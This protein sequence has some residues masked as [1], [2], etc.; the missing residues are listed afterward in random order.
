MKCTLII[1]DECNI[2]FEGLSPECRR[3]MVTSLEFFVPGAK[4]LPA[5]RLGRWNGKMSFCDIGGRSYL[6]LLDTLL[7]IVQQHGYEVEIEDRRLVTESFEFE[8][9]DTDS[10]KNVLWP[11]GHPYAGH[12]IL[13]KDHQV[14]MINSYLENLQSINI[15]PTAGGK[16]LITG[17]LSHKVQKYGRSLVIVPSKDLVTQTEIDYKNLGLDVGVFFGDRKDY[18]KTHTICTWQSLE[19]LHKNKD[20]DEM[21]AFI[22]D[23]VCVI[24]D[25]CHRAKGAVLRSLLGGPLANVPIRWGLTGT[26]PE[27]Q[28]DK[29]A[30]ISCIGA[31]NNEI[32]TKDL[33][34]KGILAGIHIDI[35]QLQDPATSY[36]TYQEELKW[37]TSNKSRLDFIAD[38][39]QNVFSTGSTL[40]LVDRIS[41]GE[42]L[43]EL[44]DGSVFVSGKMKSKDRKLEYNEVQEINNKVIIATYGIA[45]TGTNIPRLYNLVLLE[46]GKGFVRVIQSIGRGLRVTSDK[47][48]INVYDITSL[49]FNNSYNNGFAISY[50]YNASTQIY[51]IT[52]RTGNTNIALI[53]INNAY[54]SYS[55][56]QYRIYI[57]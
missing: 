56:G 57:Y 54:T 13:I 42:L 2:K 4:Y 24:S 7:P 19:A 17:I 26:M 23:V 49:Y 3:K 33:Q 36:G 31:Q 12:P 32:K 52:V 25:E 18:N 38:K 15:I 29:L 9:V 44:I 8:K 34:E 53:Y 46:P 55:V 1:K 35:W 50:T 11:E 43:E 16:T 40:I 51:S 5:V 6:N 48:F 37:L 10:Y 27:E 41:T 22:K 30:V 21:S 39:L 28:L 20:S 45:S 14:E 47:T